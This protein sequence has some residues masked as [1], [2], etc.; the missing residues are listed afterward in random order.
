[1]CN[2]EQSYNISESLALHTF[3]LHVQPF[4]VASGKFSTGRFHQ[5][6]Y[7]HLQTHTCLIFWGTGLAIELRAE[8]IQ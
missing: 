5:H 7:I 4:A 8:G 3:D 1:M 2:K 6:T